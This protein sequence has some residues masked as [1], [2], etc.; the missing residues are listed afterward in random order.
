MI[1]NLELKGGGVTAANVVAA[2]DRARLLQVNLAHHLRGRLR[3]RSAALKGD[4]NASQDARIHLGRIAGVRSVAANPCTGSL[5][6]KYD[7]T[8]LS[9]QRVIGVLAAHGCIVAAAQQSADR[10]NA[11]SDHLANAGAGSSMRSP[12]G[13]RLR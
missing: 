4:V 10:D 11:W 12:S 3:L 13:S 8:V 7:P 2:E 9:P 1:D 5:L 6:V